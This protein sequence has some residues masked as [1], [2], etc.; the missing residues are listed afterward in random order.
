MQLAISAA[1][2]TD[3]AIARTFKAM[4]IF[5]LWPASGTALMTSSSDRSEGPLLL[6]HHFAPNQI[7]PP[8]TVPPR[9]ITLAIYVRRSTTSKASCVGIEPP[10]AVHLAAYVRASQAAPRM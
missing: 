8:T 6:P 2:S 1:A 9:E 10:I 3:A 7:R 5:C 4:L